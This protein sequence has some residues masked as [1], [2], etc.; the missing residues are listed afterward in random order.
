MNQTSQNILESL[1]EISGARQAIAYFNRA[2]SDYLTVLNQSAIICQD[3]SK[4]EGQLRSASNP[5]YI[6]KLNNAYVES[7]SV[8]GRVELQSCLLNHT[9]DHLAVE[10][11]HY[12]RVNENYNLSFILRR[13]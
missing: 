10:F 1:N 9:L 13:P 11:K 6:Q 4:L 3:V 5:S 8:T 2:S 12:Q 7:S